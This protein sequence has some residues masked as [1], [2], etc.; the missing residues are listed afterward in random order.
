VA[1][2]HREND[3]VASPNPSLSTLAR[4][5][6]AVEAGLSDL[7]GPYAETTYPL[8]WDAVAQRIETG[9]IIEH[10]GLE[11]A[12]DAEVGAVLDEEG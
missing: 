6:A 9:R 4:R 1:A 7:E 8:R 11:S 2:D 12:A 5:L 10:L 3:G